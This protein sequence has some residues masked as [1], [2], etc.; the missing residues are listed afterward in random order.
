MVEGAAKQAGVRILRG[1]GFLDNEGMCKLM[2]RQG[3]RP[4]SF[5]EKY[6]HG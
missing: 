4:Y 5:F 2:E 3:Y 6:L 1:D